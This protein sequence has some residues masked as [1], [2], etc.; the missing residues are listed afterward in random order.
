MLTERT[1]EVRAW[2]ARTVK[3]LR[4]GGHVF[5][6]EVT[7]SPGGRDAVAEG[8]SADVRT[9]DE[10]AEGLIAGSDTHSDGPA[11]AALG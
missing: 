3:D 7:A 6:K 4:L 5:G 8:W 1:P 10:W 9:E 11:D 2:A